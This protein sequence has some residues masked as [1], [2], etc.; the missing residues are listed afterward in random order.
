MRLLCGCYR[1]PSTGNK[2]R[3]QNPHQRPPEG[4]PQA[5]LCV[6]NGH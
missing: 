5:K 4:Y 2:A 1:N 6:H 3:F